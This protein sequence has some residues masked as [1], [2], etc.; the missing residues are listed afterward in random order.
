[1]R[2]IAEVISSEDL[3]ALQAIFSLFNDKKTELSAFRPVLFEDNTMNGIDIKKTKWRVLFRGKGDDEFY[4]DAELKDGIY[5]T[6]VWVWED[7]KN[8]DLIKISINDLKA[9]WILQA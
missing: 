3:C 6:S 2:D 5:N 9:P 7:R 1:M 8:P 4:I